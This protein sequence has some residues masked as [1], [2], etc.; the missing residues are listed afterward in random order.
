[1][2]WDWASSTHSVNHIK[3]IETLPSLQCLSPVPYGLNEVGDAG[4]VGMEE[5][6]SSLHIRA[7]TKGLEKKWQKRG[8]E[9]PWGVRM[10]GEE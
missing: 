6:M 3:N 9:V 7:H 10:D 8:E 5:C 1:L 2:R 4:G